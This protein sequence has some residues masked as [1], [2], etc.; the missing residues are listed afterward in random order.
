MT[1]IVPRP[2]R[3]FSWSEFCVSSTV[4][5][6]ELSAALMTAPAH[7]VAIV[8][9]CAAVLDPLRDRVGPIRVTSGYRT[10]RLNT[11]IGGSATSDH[12]TGCAADIKA[13]GG[14]AS[15]IADA[16]TFPDGVVFTEG[17]N[18]PA[19]PIDQ[20]ITYALSRGGHVHVSYRLKRGAVRDQYLHAP[21]GGGYVPLPPHDPEC[22]MGYDCTCD[23]LG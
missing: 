19:L 18:C 9:L 21:A 23:R 4:D 5:P 6:R 11:A 3:W 17:G 12:M 7:Q 16:A 22:D 20:L 10:R 1:W 15:W 13:A 14:D 2:G 8:A